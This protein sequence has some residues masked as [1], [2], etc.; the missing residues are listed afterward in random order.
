MRKF[1]KPSRARTRSALTN[2]ADRTGRIS[3][4]KQEPTTS[5][6]S[7]DSRFTA[8]RGLVGASFS[9]NADGSVAMKVITK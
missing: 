6:Y 7:M 5:T 1:N 2:V 3:R 8:N 4:P 9:F